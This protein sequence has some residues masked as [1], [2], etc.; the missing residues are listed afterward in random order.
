MPALGA[1]PFIA[2]RMMPGALTE[3]LLQFFNPRDEHKKGKFKAYYSWALGPTSSMI[4]RFRSVG[5]E[6]VEYVGCFGHDYYRRRSRLLDKVESLKS[7]MLVNRPVPWLCS[8]VTVCLQ[9][10]AYSAPFCKE[11][12]RL[13]RRPVKGPADNN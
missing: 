13:I 9:K 8:Y 6:V 2:N 10:P 12:D 7:R 1:L 5:Y 11:V 3:K 4:K